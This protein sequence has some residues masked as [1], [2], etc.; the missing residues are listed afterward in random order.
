MVDERSTAGTLHLEGVQ[1]GTNQDEI[2][3]SSFVWDNRPLAL[4]DL[5][6]QL[7]I[8]FEE[9]VHEV[10]EL[11]TVDLPAP[12]KG[13]LRGA[14]L[15]PPLLEVVTKI[16]HHLRS[17]ASQAAALAGSTGPTSSLMSSPIS[18]PG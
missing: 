18:L 9:D 4:L 15:R 6:R 11:L 10:L 14:N 16:V 17:H 3:I 5:G 2:E 8:E 1:K 12:A 13:V 7:Q